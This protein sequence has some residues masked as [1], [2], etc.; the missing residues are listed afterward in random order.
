MLRDE[1]STAA[2]RILR[3]SPSAGSAPCG[4]LPREVAAGHRPRSELSGPTRRFVPVPALWMQAAGSRRQ[5]ATGFRIGPV[6]STYD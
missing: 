6:Q 3:A 4:M 1:P 5:K 2:V